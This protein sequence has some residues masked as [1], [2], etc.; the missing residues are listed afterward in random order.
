MGN[1]V[2]GMLEGEQTLEFMRQENE[3]NRRFLE[4]ILQETVVICCG[5]NWTGSRVVSIL[6]K[7]LL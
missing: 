7:T 2:S 5:V 3:V 6:P 4:V 1:P